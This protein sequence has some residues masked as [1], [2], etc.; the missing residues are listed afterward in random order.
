MTKE[1][2]VSEWWWLTVNV[3]WASEWQW[4]GYFLCKVF[5]S[6]RAGQKWF[7]SPAFQNVRLCKF[8]WANIVH[9]Q[10]SKIRSDA[11]QPQKLAAV[12][13]SQPVREGASRGGEVFSAW[14]SHAAGPHWI[15]PP[16]CSQP[17]N[18]QITAQLQHTM[19]TTDTRARLW[20]GPYQ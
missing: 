8:V 13:F 11:T 19:V 7:L 16:R 9:K 20:G 5:F 10:K 3:Q 6:D 12:I 1:C 15:S 18:Y 14:R 4:R 2:W 17:S